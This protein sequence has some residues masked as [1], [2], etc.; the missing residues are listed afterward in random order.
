MLEVQGGVRAA[1]F[2][3]L[4]TTDRDGVPVPEGLGHLMQPGASTRFSPDRAI[5]ACLYRRLTLRGRDAPNFFS[6]QRNQHLP[7]TFAAEAKLVSASGGAIGLAPGVRS[8]L[9][10]R[11][12]FAD[13]FDGAASARSREWRNGPGNRRGRSYIP[14]TPCLCERPCQHRRSPGAAARAA[15][16]A[17]G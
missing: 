13:A 15:G 4:R 9:F 14:G 1:P 17:H 16:D 8:S 3:A 5:G 11:V 6:A 2:T 10:G 12:T 7:R